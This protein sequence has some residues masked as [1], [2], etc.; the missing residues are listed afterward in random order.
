M[1]FRW[2][3]ISLRSFRFSESPLRFELYFASLPL[4]LQ[5]I[6]NQLERKFNYYL[7]CR[8]MIGRFLF[9]LRSLTPIPFIL[10][11]VYF[12]RPSL[13]SILIG[14][15]FLALG[16]CLRLWTVGYA[17]GGT[18][19]RTLGA[20]RD[21]VTTG[22]YAYVRNPL[23]LGNLLLSLGVCFVASVYWMIIVLMVGYLIQYLPIVTSEETY[24]RKSCGSIYEAYY[25]A[26]PRFM[27]RI[28]RYPNPSLHDFSFSRAFKSEKRTLT[29]IA[30][31]IGLI[32]GRSLLLR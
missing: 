31:V 14:V 29:A 17:G 30:C 18:R 28:R 2:I 23:Y 10:I 25:A 16:E 8:K 3:G 9:R 22:P 32:A 13:I 27:P 15:V 7:G 1:Y 5:V 21:L 20:A 12:S 11:L 6:E 4:D 19:S 24:L 26:V